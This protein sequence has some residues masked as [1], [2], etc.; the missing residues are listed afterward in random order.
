M[1][2]VLRLIVRPIPISI[3]SRNLS[4]AIHPQNSRTSASFRKDSAHFTAF[5]RS[6]FEWRCD[7]RTL[8]SPTSEHIRLDSR[9]KQNRGFTF[10]DVG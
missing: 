1:N 3:G 2:W 7:F 8:A 10:D 9:E 6:R 4:I 5:C